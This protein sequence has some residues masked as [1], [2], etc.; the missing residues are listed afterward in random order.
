MTGWADRDDTRE[1][2]DT[3]PCVCPDCEVDLRDGP[4]AP[5]CGESAVNVVAVPGAAAP[6]ADRRPPVDTDASGDTDAPGAA[7]PLTLQAT[8]VRCMRAVPVNRTRP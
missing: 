7:T 6:D 4:H 3:P 8:A 1:D 2:D 5:G